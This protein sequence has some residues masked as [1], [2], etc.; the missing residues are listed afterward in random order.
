M[1]QDWLRNA[2]QV[3]DL[4]HDSFVERHAVGDMCV[5]TIDEQLVDGPRP[6]AWAA[7]FR[8]AGDLGEDE[9]RRL[10]RE[11]A[12]GAESGWDY[13]SRWMGGGSDLREM[14]TT[15]IVPV[16]LNSILIKVERVLAALHRE[17]GDEKRGGHYEAVA[18]RRADALQ[19]MLWDGEKGVWC[20][21]DLRHKRSTGVLA[22]SAFFP[23]WA[24]CWPREWEDDSEAGV[25]L[26][27]KLKP[28]IRTG[29]LVT[30]LERSGQQ[31][32]VG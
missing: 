3:L 17:C 21:Y 26:I 11:L 28:L 7:D 19:E 31:W 29:G 25:A 22:A 13:S 5:Y 27:V 2:L 24:G 14:R 9:R 12:A 18:R 10:Y 32:D 15:E 30:T 6:E 4:E 20:D 16:C 1:T 8:V 23:L